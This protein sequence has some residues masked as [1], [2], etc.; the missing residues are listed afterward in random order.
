MSLDPMS[1]QLAAERLSWTAEV[2]RGLAEPL[3]ALI[4]STAR[5]KQAQAVGVPQESSTR[6]QKHSVLHALQLID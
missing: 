4:A 6:F 2:A 3:P 1:L 5:G